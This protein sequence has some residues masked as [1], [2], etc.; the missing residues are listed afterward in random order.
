MDHG[1]LLQCGE[2]TEVRLVKNYKG[3]SKGYAYVEFTQPVS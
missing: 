1:I 3:K 2:I